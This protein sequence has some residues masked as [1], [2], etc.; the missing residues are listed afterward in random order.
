MKLSDLRVAFFTDNGIAAADGDTVETVRRAAR[1]LEG[2]VASVEERRPP[3]IEA[4]YDLEMK[5]IGPDGGDG[6][7]AYLRSIG[8]WETHPVLEGWLGK[9]E[10]YRTDLAGFAR[11]WAELDRFRDAMFG[12]LRGYDV[13]LSPV[14]A[15]AG[16]AT[17]GVGARRG[18]SGVRVYDD[19]QLDGVAGGGWCAGGLRRRGCRSGCR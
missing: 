4:S 17:W 11:Y 2:H 7:R 19:V 10:A 12:F 14:S 16:G 3:G 15:G 6:L 8:S 5:M 1:A 9:L 18:I 13:I